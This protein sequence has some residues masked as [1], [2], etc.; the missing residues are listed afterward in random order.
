MRHVGR[1]LALAAIS[2][3]QRFVSP[4]KGFRCAYAH[5]TG[6]ASCSRL[7][8]RAIRMRG[9]DVGIR[10][11]FERFERCRAA[12]L[13]HT[14]RHAAAGRVAS[15]GPARS[16]GPRRLQRGFCEVLACVPDA[17]CIA[18]PCDV[19]GAGPTAFDVANCCCS[20]PCPSLPCDLWER[21]QA[22]P[23]ERARPFVDRR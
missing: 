6:C 4:Y 3:Y 15:G 20:T 17:G 5:H 23:G 2:F 14:H 12:H 18:A 13:R 10:L 8:Y 7:G 11:L 22:G 21:R 16:V 9:V 19:V 1:Y